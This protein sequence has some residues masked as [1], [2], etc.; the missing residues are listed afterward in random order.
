VDAM[1]RHN[2]QDSP[3]LSAAARRPAYP[4]RR[5]LRLGPTVIIAVA[6]LALSQLGAATA[7]AA[8]YHAPVSAHFIPYGNCPPDGLP[9]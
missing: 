3:D 7:S 8:V 6:S 1:P 9:C 5:T 2:T 4:I